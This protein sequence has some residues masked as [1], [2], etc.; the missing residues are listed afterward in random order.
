M[1]NGGS[2]DARLL[3]FAFFVSTITL[4]AA[5]CFRLLASMNDSSC[6]IV[7]DVVSNEH[8]AYLVLCCPW[9]VK[10]SLLI[11]LSHDEQII[12]PFAAYED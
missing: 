10:N 12:R 3:A 1:N 6:H 11:P 5:S 7:E 8:P 9:S 2:W 4:S